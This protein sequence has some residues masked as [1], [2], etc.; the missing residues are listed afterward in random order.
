M[1]DWFWDFLYSIT[2]SIFRIIDGLIDSCL[3]LCGINTVKIDGDDVDFLTW[4]FQ[5]DEIKTGFATAALVGIVLIVFFSVW[6]ILKTIGSEKIQDTP[7]KICMKAFKNVMI[8]LLIPGIMVVLI[9][10]LNV[11]GKVMYAGTMS[12][13][14]SLG[15]YLALSFGRDAANDPAQYADLLTGAIAVNFTDTSDMK[16][17]FDLSDYD[18]FF[19]WVAGIAILLTLAKALFI[20]VDRMFSITI[21]YIISPF[22]IA[23][24][25]VDDGQRF[26][27]WRDQILIKFLTGYA[28]IVGINI[29]AVIISNICT[30]DITFFPDNAFLD[31]IL[32][33]VIVVGGT[34]SLNRIIALVGNIIQ[35]GAGEAELRNAEGL[36]G[37]FKGAVGK[38]FGVAAAGING[39]GKLANMIR[40]KSNDSKS[41]SGSNSSS[42]SNKSSSSKAN[43]DGT[44]NKSPTAQN[45]QKS[46]TN[47]GSKSGNAVM[48]AIGGSTNSGETKK[49]DD[50]KMPT[51]PDLKNNAVNKVM[52]NNSVL[53]QAKEKGG[54]KK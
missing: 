31:F 34:L 5:R 6:Q 44:S 3:Y 1:F 7:A 50:N 21:L 24:S 4:I 18:Y 47:N 2:K 39:V 29:F 46:K 43:G 45:D 54:N 49:S 42:D 37:G 51:K 15:Q 27:A 16:R 38:A 36:S 33:I 14:T 8:F 53:N 48:K 32:K 19:S 30:A 41:G 11:L 28:T 20:F 40:G 23:S 17:F 52:N 9:G 25:I 26:K 10:A 22:A 13:S 12:N 35:Q